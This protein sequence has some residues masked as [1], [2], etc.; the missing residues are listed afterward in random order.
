MV[1]I[2]DFFK[3]GKLTTAGGALA[4]LGGGILG[5]LGGG[6]QSQGSQGYT[7]GIPE[8][9]ATREPV[10]GVYESA[11]RRPGQVGRRYFTDVAYTPKLTTEGTQAVMGGDYLAD[12]NAQALQAEQ[13]RE[14][15]G[16]ALL[17]L[18]QQGSTPATPATPA[19]PTTP[20]TTPSWRD[21]SDEE[22]LMSIDEWKNYSGLTGPALIEHAV[23][24]LGEAGVSPYR[25]ASLTNIPLANIQRAY[26]KYGYAEGGL[27][28]LKG[29]GYYL[30][31]ATDGMADRVPATIDGREPARL[32]DG[33]FVI[34]ADVVSHLGNGNSDAG[35]KQLYSMMD[36]VRKA[37]TGTTRQGREIDPRKYLAR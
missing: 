6:G 31:G 18:L 25:I 33:E 9:E 36:R 11:G 17:Q 12:L 3:K 8:Y 35:A 22:I 1:G 21:I 32:S 15:Q 27:A 14:A 26:S 23:T 5:A 20:T 24:K 19:T 16:L 2:E 4:A 37:R 13:D 28:S 7:G 10:P 30:G 34:P 29:K